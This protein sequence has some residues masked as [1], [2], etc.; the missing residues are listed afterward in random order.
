MKIK[1]VVAMWVSFIAGIAVVGGS[2]AYM[3]NQQVQDAIDS[4][5][6]TAFV[7][8]APA[9]LLK[10]VNSQEAFTTFAAKSK[11]MQAAHEAI[12]ANV[13]ATVQ[14]NDYDAFQ[15]VL[16]DEQNARE[17]QMFD[18]LVTTYKE[19]GKLPEWPMWG[20]WMMKGWFGHSG[21]MG[22]WHWHARMFWNDDDP[23]DNDDEGEAQN[24]DDDTTTAADKTSK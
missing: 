7:N 17:K 24:S 12:Q 21:K 20:M 2:F 4:N 16:T 5:D 9:K 6:Y 19:T 15:K 13:L 1:N 22:E 14:A 23:V 3:G 11:E 18:T 10:K 8:N